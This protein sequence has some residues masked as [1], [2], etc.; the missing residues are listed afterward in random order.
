MSET[1]VIERKIP[2]LLL[3]A[4]GALAV[5]IGLY[6]FA[7][8]EA[9]PIDK[10]PSVTA[11]LAPPPTPIPE[12]EPLEVQAVAPEKA[13]EINTAVPFSTRPNPAAKP[14]K[15]VGLET[16]MAR[17]VDCL[18]AALY[19]EA[20][21]EALEGQRAVAQVVLNRVRHPA[22]PKT[23]CGVVF[24]GQE[25][26]TGC[27]FSFTCD[28]AM[29]RIPSADSWKRMQDIARS[30][31]TG[32]VYKPVGL[33]THYHTDWVVPVWSASLEKI[34]AE[35]THLFFRW[36]GW[37]GTPTAFRGQYAGN[38]ASIGKLSNVSLV[39]SG[40]DGVI[41]GLTIDRE[42]GLPIPAPVLAEQPLRPTGPSTATPR[43]VNAAGDFKIF[44]VDRRTDP[45]QLAVIA[46]TAC[47]GRQ[48]CKILMWTD[49]ASVPSALPVT[50]AQLNKLSFSYLRNVNS[51]YDKALW[52]C[53]LFAKADPDH[54]MTQRAPERQPL[55]RA[56]RLFPAKPKADDA[57][58]AVTEPLTPAKPVS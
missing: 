39:H 16:D 19:Y 31:L 45:K 12:A 35:R 13:V 52:N 53:D 22:F 33:A 1:R 24:Q 38:E 55:D 7:T 34:R 11:Q 18:A 10:A 28:G 32:S 46:Q 6:F 21:N 3:W 2:H 44:L 50:E 47:I 29:A 57:T 26:S 14:F 8:P 27:Q 36:A 40:T 48:Y 25:R 51:G 17:A 58:T 56:A 41:D 5:L 30:A 43:F 4:V 49:G 23:V 42:T 15:L 54:C 9:R 37:W 20:G